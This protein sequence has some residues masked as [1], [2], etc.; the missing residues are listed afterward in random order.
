MTPTFLQ[1]CITVIRVTQC[2]HF[3]VEGGPSN[4]FTIM[5]MHHE[6]TC[7]LSNKQFSYKLLVIMTS[8]WSD[9]SLLKYL[10]DTGI[11]RDENTKLSL[12]IHLNIIFCLGLCLLSDLFSSG[13]LNASKQIWDRMLKQ[14]TDTFLYSMAHK[15]HSF[16]L[17]KVELV[18]V[19]LISIILTTWFVFW[20][21]WRQQWRIASSGTSILKSFEMAS[22]A[23][24]PKTSPAV[25]SDMKMLNY[26]V[27]T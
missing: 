2:R 15:L 14:A 24:W 27:T 8:K 21:I 20:A 10:E 26:T 5:M 25:Y 19:L 4:T 13:V 11:F 16:W 22:N 18:T 7:D 17:S 12:I 3:A 23:V 6:A 1:Q 9:Y